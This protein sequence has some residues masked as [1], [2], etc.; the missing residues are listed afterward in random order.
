VTREVDGHSGLCTQGLPITTTCGDH[1]WRDLKK[2]AISINAF[3]FRIIRFFFNSLENVLLTHHK[4]SLLSSALRLVLKPP[5]FFFFFGKIKI[6]STN[7]FNLI[8]AYKFKI[9]PN[10]SK[11]IKAIIMILSNLYSRYLI[12]YANLMLTLANLQI[13]EAQ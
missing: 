10:L 3:A 11:R 7:Y 12:L 5:F 13:S 6:D 9:I 2:D 1:R 8:I 4:L